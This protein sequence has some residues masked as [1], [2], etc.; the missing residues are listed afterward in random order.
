[1]VEIKDG[2]EVEAAVAAH[3]PGIIF[4][5]RH[6]ACAPRLAHRAHRADLLAQ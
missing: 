4:M 5:D 1:M 3:Q 6:S 2:D